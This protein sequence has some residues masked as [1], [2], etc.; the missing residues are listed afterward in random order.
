MSDIKISISSTI[1]APVDTVF[2]VITDFERY[3]TWNPGIVDAGFELV[4][5]QDGVF[6][7]HKY[8]GKS[9]LN[10]V[11][12]GCDEKLLME[13]SGW[14]NRFM[15]STYL[16]TLYAGSHGDTL[17]T[18]DINLSGPASW[19]AGKI[20]KKRIRRMIQKDVNALKKHCE[21]ISHTAIN[22]PPAV[23]SLD[24]KNTP[25][26]HQTVSHD[27]DLTLHTN[28]EKEYSTAIMLPSSV[29]RH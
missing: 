3:K 10:I 5:G 16:V 1:H 22:K 25:D 18:L 28:T 2:G 7:W 6:T 9:H 4:D 17:Y 12:V 19:L 21:K 27:I 26:Y 20:L 14:Q 11:D 29:T 23:R 13:S 24:L 15:R 8:F